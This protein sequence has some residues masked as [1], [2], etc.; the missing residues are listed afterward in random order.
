MYSEQQNHS[1]KSQISLVS[2]IMA[3]Q[4]KVNLCEICITKV[5]ILYFIVPNKKHLALLVDFILT[6]G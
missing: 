1:T 2:Q 5:D 3:Q 6:L 4:T